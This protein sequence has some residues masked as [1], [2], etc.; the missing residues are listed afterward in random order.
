MET[1][2]I[3]IRTSVKSRRVDRSTK[4]GWVRQNWRIL[5]HRPKS[6]R[7]EGGGSARVTPRA[8]GIVRTH[9]LVARTIKRSTRLDTLLSLTDR[10]LGKVFTE[11]M[12]LECRQ[13]GS[14]GSERDRAKVYQE[15]GDMS[16]EKIKCRK[17]ADALLA[18]LQILSRL[19]N[20][21]QVLGSRQEMRVRVCR[22]SRERVE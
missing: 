11:F 14:D 18:S 1:W 6:P 10:E 7:R 4:S 22:M 20:I 12:S 9:T 16:Q 8:G 2:R 13:R 19:D 15:R 17:V 21:T 3:S 5:R